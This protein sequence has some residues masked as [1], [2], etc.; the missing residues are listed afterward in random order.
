[1]N[2]QVEVFTSDYIALTVP[3]HFYGE[4]THINDSLFQELKDVSGL[5][6][7]R[8]L[9]RSLPNIVSNVT[10]YEVEQNGDLK[11]LG[12]GISGK[13]KVYQVIYDYSQTQT[14]VWGSGENAESVLVGIG[15]RMVAKVKTKKAGINLSSP[16]GLTANTKKVE[17]SLEVRVTGISSSK[18]NGI[19]PTTT[20][21][22]ASSI[23][24][25]LQAVATIKSHIHDKETIITPQY[26][27]Y[28]KIDQTIKNENVNT[29]KI[30]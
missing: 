16:F 11:V 18:I 3:Q 22:S 29:Q 20:D 1:M 4:I 26:L 2:A 8:T 17:G 15:V 21:L 10:V 6:N 23:S 9:L 28:N 27:G 5:K 24:V 12:I 13:N 7:D 30:N 25:A 19:I 14:L